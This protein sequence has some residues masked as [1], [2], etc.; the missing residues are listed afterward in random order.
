MTKLEGDALPAIEWYLFE[1]L[2]AQ[3]VDVLSQHPE[4][5]GETTV[6]EALDV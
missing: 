3:Q 1:I 2:V 6:D 4:A 5:G